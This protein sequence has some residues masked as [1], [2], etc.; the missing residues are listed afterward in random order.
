MHYLYIVLVFHAV[1]SLKLLQTHMIFFYCSWKKDFKECHGRLLSCFYNEWGLKLKNGYNSTI[2]VSWKRYNYS[3]HIHFEP[4]LNIFSEVHCIFAFSLNPD[5][6]ALRNIKKQAPYKKKCLC[7]PSRNVVYVFSQERAVPASPPT[8][9]PAPITR[10]PKL[11][12][13]WL[14]VKVKHMV[15]IMSRNACLTPI[16][17]T[18][19]SRFLTHSLSL[20]EMLNILEN[21]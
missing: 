12:E 11:K 16:R 2:K 3:S 19:L 5:P 21:L 10:P 17:L 9:A 8:W 14:P 20:Y 4:K 15:L 6:D 1:V 18:S 7:T 13:M